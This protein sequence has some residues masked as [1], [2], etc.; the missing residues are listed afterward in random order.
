MIRKSTD[1]TNKDSLALCVCRLASYLEV[2][3]EL[4]VLLFESFEFAPG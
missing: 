1:T 3:K 4:Q 2:A